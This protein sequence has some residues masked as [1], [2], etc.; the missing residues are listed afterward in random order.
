M[1]TLMTSRSKSRSAGTRPILGALCCSL[2]RSARSLYYPTFC[3]MW[4][5]FHANTPEHQRCSSPAGSW[6]ACCRVNA[7]CAYDPHAPYSV[8]PEPGR[9]PLMLMT[10]LVMVMGIALPFSPLASYLHPQAASVELLPMAGGDSGRLYGADADGGK[11]ST[12]VDMGGSKSPHP[13]LTLSPKGRG[14]WGE[15]L[16]FLPNS[17]TCDLRRLLRLTTI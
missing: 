8:H 1:I 11:G 16:R 15:G 3:L 4:F 7:N 10:L 5:V 17:T 12:P 14:P 2:G 6:S 9:L 13:L